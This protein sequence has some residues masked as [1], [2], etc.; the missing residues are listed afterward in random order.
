MTIDDGDL[1]RNIDFSP[2]L[3]KQFLNKYGKAIIMAAFESYDI[4][5]YGTQSEWGAPQHRELLSDILQ[6]DL[7]L[8]KQV[9]DDAFS[10]EGEGYHT[11]YFGADGDIYEI[12]DDYDV[13]GMANS[14]WDVANSI[15]LY[16]AIHSGFV[17]QQWL[18]AAN[19]LN[20]NLDDKK[21][22]NKIEDMYGVFDE[23]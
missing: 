21:L 12:E 19:D 5:L 4:P 3:V 18:K 6:F 9:Y 2:A 14:W 16:E 8:L 15:S 13:Q 17:S 7:E 22:V 23:E 10:D 11:P 1:I 20:I